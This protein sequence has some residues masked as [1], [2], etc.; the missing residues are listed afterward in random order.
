MTEEQDVVGFYEE[1]AKGYEKER[2]LT[3]SG[4]YEDETQKN[5][6]LNLLNSGKLLILDV[7]CGTGRFSIET[8]KQGCRVIA[9]DPALSMLKELKTKIKK[10]SKI[11]LIR[12]SGYEL[13]FKTS[14]FDGCTCINVLNHLSNYGQ[15]LTEIHRILKS[16]AFVI[17][18][19]P[20]LVS[21]LFPAGLLINLREKSL[22]NPVYAK[23]YT[24]REIKKQLHAEGFTVENI[25]GVILPAG[26]LIPLPIVK[27]INQISEDSFLKYIGMGLFVKAVVN[28]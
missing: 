3:D 21:P 19:F 7:G 11:T 28:K 20:N 18:S 25:K 1:D 27:K 26:K 14:T 9:L 24:L 16:M 10:D 13:P 15:V 5:I 6:V 23:W 22:L 17:F 12:G 8:A 4:K 2:F